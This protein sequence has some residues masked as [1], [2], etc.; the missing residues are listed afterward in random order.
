MELIL[1]SKVG[2]L[3]KPKTSKRFVINIPLRIG[4]RLS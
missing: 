2:I 4:N 1:H 3:V